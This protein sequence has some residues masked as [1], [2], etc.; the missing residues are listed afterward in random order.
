[1]FFEDEDFT[2]RQ[3]SSQITVMSDFISHEC[4]HHTLHYANLWV[5]FTNVKEIIH[6]IQCV[7][8]VLMQVNDSPIKH[9]NRHQISQK[10]PYYCCFKSKRFIVLKQLH[11]SCWRPVD[12]NL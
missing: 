7:S 11:S 8:G 10:E 3:E 9:S 4:R 12:L 6:L 1:M 2:Q 5:K